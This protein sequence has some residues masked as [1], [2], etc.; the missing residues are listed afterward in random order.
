MKTT[1]LVPYLGKRPAG[2]EHFAYSASFVKDADFVL[3]TN[4]PSGVRTYPNF[5]VAPFSLSD[6]NSLASAAVGCG[7]ESSNV[8][9]MC[10]FRPA[11]GLIFANLLRDS[12]YWGYCD[13]DVMFGDMSKYLQPEF[14]SQYDVIS[15]N[16]CYL[17]GS[18]TLWRNDSTTNHL[19][20]LSPDWKRL[21]MSREHHAFDECGFGLWP[22]LLAGASIFDV[23]CD[24][25]SMTH[26]VRMLEREG[27]IRPHFRM[28]VKEIFAESEVLKWRPGHVSTV[29]PEPGEEYAY[30]H[31]VLLKQL[32]T[33]YIPSWNPMPQEMYISHSGYHRK[34]SGAVSHATT[35][36]R[37]ARLK[38]R[39]FPR[40]LQRRL[41]GILPR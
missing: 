20:E 13:T 26:V 37:F 5:R 28:L 1:I 6:F 11:F 36:Q 18:F 23:P 34:L 24:F 14:L 25:K 2:F 29:F 8:A 15:M 31:S 12:D 9:K 4:D 35:I 33:F 39:N 17:S 3:L 16:A 22:Q 27:R 21:M 41:R 7:I 19:F 30:F 40:G 32:K 38:I 10:D